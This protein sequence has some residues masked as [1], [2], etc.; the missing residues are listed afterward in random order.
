MKPDSYFKCDLK[1]DYPKC[2][3]LSKFYLSIHLI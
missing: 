2:I 3:F 1:F